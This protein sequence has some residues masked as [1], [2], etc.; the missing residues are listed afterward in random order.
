MRAPAFILSFIGLWVGLTLLGGC[1]E[2]DRPPAAD[3]GGDAHAADL[4][5]GPEASPPGDLGADR[6][7]GPDSAAAD[8]GPARDGPAGEQ[9]PPPDQGPPCQE[10]VVGEACTKGG[11]ECG[12]GHECLLVSGSAGFC[13]CACQVDDP[14]TPLYFEDS[15]PGKDLLCATYKVGS[16]PGRPL[17]FL[18]LGGTNVYSP[19]Y[20]GPADSAKGGA[21]SARRKPASYPFTV[22]GVFYKLLGANAA[23]DPDLAHSLGFAV[24]T[25]STPPSSPTLSASFSVGAGSSGNSIRFVER[26][27]PTPLTLTSGQYGY[28]I[29]QQPVASKSGKGLCLVAFV[30][31]YDQGIHTAPQAA[32]PYT[33]TV[34]KIGAQISLLGF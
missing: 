15:C 22:L 14:Q 20:V 11:H 21:I 26:F 25:S 7:A 9:G 31:S 6:W 8:A 13:T 27:L 24:S 33:W 2:Q 3:G 29:I 17:C 19:D 34:Q 12:A 4:L 30:G 23:C 10:K 5:P 28:P 1:E 18:R 32:A 16:G